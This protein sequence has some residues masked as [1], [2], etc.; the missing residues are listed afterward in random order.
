MKKLYHNLS[1]AIIVMLVAI[2]PL[3]SI[4]QTTTPPK[5]EEPKKA[6]NSAPSNSYWSVTVYGGANQFNGDLSKN[7]FL[8]DKWMFGAG[9]MVTKQFGRTLGARFRFGWAPLSASVSKKYVPLGGLVD[10]FTKQTGDYI[11]QRFTSYVLESDL[12]VTI[13]WVNWILGS[14]PERF[15]SSYLIAGI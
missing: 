11:N 14:K 13:N 3:V 4:A 6:N 12:E 15:F 10:P 2:V 7:L 5:K 9:A 1:R 8:N